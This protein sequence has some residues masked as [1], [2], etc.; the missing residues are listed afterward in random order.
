M[1]YTVGECDE[2]E[3]RLVGGQTPDEGRVEICLNREWGGVC[4][5]KWDIRDAN[6][7]CTQLGYN[8]SKLDYY[9]I[10]L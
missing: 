10:M 1:N 4:D 3:V 2:T 7:V 5:D 6:V 9:P 8:G